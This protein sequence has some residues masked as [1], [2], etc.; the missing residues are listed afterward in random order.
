MQHFSKDLY[1]YLHSVHVQYNIYEQTL[2]DH[3]IGYI[4]A[5]KFALNLL[6]VWF[7]DSFSV[8]V[9]D[10][11][12]DT[13]TTMLEVKKNISPSKKKIVKVRNAANGGVA[14][15]TFQCLCY[16]EIGRSKTGRIV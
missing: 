9:M 11:N 7:V 10:A 13:N 14:I 16:F 1:I 15:E 6:L 4:L 12:Q 3:S 5:G 8:L 2:T